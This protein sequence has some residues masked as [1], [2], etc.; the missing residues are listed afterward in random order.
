MLLA[1]SFMMNFCIWIIFQRNV[2]ESRIS[3][4]II[5]SSLMLSFIINCC[6]FASLTRWTWVWV[7]SRSWW[8]TGKPGV[9]QSMGSQRVGHNWVTELN[10]TDG[11]TI[12]IS[13]D[14]KKKIYFQSHGGAPPLYRLVLEWI[15]PKDGIE[16]KLLLFT[17]P[18]VVMLEY[19]TVWLSNVQEDFIVR[20]V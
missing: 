4:F 18:T 13:A 19:V 20:R 1:V 9:L 7:G 10:W 2:D 11:M 15:C 8:W 14:V 6:Q 5:P 17:T 3:F 12:V 16:I